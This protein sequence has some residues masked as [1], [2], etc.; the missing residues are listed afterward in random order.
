MSEKIKSKI[1]TA[2]KLGFAIFST[3]MNVIYNMRSLYYMMFLTNILELSADEAGTIVAI[4]VAWDA[5]NDP[6]IGLFCNNRRFKNGEKIRPYALWCAVPFAI[7]AIL[8]FTD[9]GLSHTATLVVCVLVYFLFEIFNTFIC[10]PY[11]SMGSLAT[12]LDSDRRS[13]NM[14]RS[15]GACIGSALGTLCVPMIMKLFGGLKESK[16]ISKADA[17]PLIFTA[18]A[19]GAVCVIGCLAHYFTTAER[20]EPKEK[21]E[22]KLSLLEVY[23]L[24]FSCKSWVFNMLYV[25]GYGINNALM[26]T[27]ITYYASYI[28][29]DV[30]AST[31]ILACY[32][33]TAVIISLTAGKIDTALGRKKT[34]ILSCVVQ[35]LG[36]VPF[37]IN[38]LGSLGI[39]I[40]A[41]TTG[42]GAT[43]AFIMF[44]TNRNNIVDI[45]EYEKGKRIDSLAGAGDNLITKFAE[46]IANKLIGSLLAISGF[47]AALGLAQPGEVITSIC[48]MLGW[49]P[50]AIAVFMTIV[51]CIMDITKE[52]NEAKASYEA[53]NK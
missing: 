47:V 30:S 10:I 37:I 29:G 32:L 31:P 17:K 36:K 9:F 13:I 14:F 5:I 51:V 33:V 45:I 42:F 34:M 25:L 40:N 16:I 19:L 20:V 27:N 43:L 44:N 26:M 52:Y 41:I 23:K 53:G 2:E 38:P 46:A 12:D 50:A 3:A 49:I 35:A 15:L 11:N 1:T 48:A 24:L 8:V 4:G 28:L 6:L 39:Y 7:S 21:H 18:I 22:D